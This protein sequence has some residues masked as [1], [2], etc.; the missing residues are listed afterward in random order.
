MSHSRYTVW[1][2]RPVGCCYIVGQTDSRQFAMAIADHALTQFPDT[3]KLDVIDMDNGIWEREDFPNGFPA[4]TES[5]EA[6]NGYWIVRQM[7]NRI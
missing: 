5:Y 7:P 2:T 3:I 4:F 6:V 1:V